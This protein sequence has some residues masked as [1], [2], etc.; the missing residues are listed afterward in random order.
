MEKFLWPNQSNIAKLPTAFDRCDRV[1]FCDDSIFRGGAT[2][3]NKESQEIPDECRFKNGSFDG[4]P[5]KGL[6]LRENG[7]VASKLRGVVWLRRFND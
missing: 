2:D 1:V 5:R 4:I 7:A 6:R 3:A